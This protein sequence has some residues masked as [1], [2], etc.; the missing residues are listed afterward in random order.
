MS[1]AKEFKV[2]GDCQKLGHLMPTP[3]DRPSGKDG[4]NRVES[5]D[6][7]IQG[8]SIAERLGFCAEI[9][10]PETVKHER[11][12]KKKNSPI[13]AFNQ[14]KGAGIVNGMGSPRSGDR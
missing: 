11:G 1:S 5:D 13:D 3:C 9:D 6:H 14:L 4:S 2:G 10:I 7:Q 8:K 12:G